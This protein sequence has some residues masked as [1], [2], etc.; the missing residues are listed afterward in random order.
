MGDPLSHHPASQSLGHNS[1]NQACS[2]ADSTCGNQPGVGSAVRERQFKSGRKSACSAEEGRLPQ[3]SRLWPLCLSC[4]LG[5][6][7]VSSAKHLLT[8]GDLLSLN[9]EVARPGRRGAFVY[10]HA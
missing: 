7:N 10:S 9:K 8:L 2:R 4:A 6:L 3:P 5:S 1:H